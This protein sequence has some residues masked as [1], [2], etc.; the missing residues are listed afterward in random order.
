MPGQD[1]LWLWQ[2]AVRTRPELRS[3]FLLLGSEPLPEP[4][5]RDYFTQSER[6]LA[7][8]FILHAL[9]HEVDAIVRRDDTVHHPLPPAPPPLGPAATAARPAARPDPTPPPAQ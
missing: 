1:G 5:T 7:K 4:R 9:C 6:L 2:Q 3:R 8:P